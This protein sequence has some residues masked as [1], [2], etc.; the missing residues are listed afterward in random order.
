MNFVGTGGIN[1]T[2]VPHTHDMAQPSSTAS[3]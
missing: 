2:L 3:T 1:F